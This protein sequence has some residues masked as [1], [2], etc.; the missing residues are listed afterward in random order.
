MAG[1]GRIHIPACNTRY[2]IV[3]TSFAS[4]SI[5]RANSGPAVTYNLLFVRNLYL[6]EESFLD[7]RGFDVL[8]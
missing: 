3:L 6:I 8:G 4:G 5:W 7:K 1:L 2:G